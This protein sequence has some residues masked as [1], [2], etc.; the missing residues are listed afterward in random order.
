MLCGSV[1][2]ASKCGGVGGKEPDGPTIGGNS[3]GWNIASS[4]RPDKVERVKELVEGKVWRPDI[5]DLREMAEI[6]LLLPD[7]RSKESLMNWGS[8]S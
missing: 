2:S 7:F 4:A 6:R 5:D 3:R 8:S 1:I